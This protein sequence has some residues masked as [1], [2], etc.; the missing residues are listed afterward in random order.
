MKLFGSTT[1][2]YEAGLAFEC[3]GCGRCCAGPEEGYVW[4]TPAEIAAIAAH[5]GL[6]EAQMRRRYVRRVGR[7]FSLKERAESRD[8]V[9]L[10]PPASHD[11]RQVRGCRIYPVRPRQCRT[12]PFWPGNV[13]SPAAW[14]E[15]G[16]RC[17]GIN[18]GRVHGPDR[19]ER[20]RN[21]T[22]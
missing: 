19:I 1:A 5:L 18:R 2:W 15:A 7:R 21:G 8:C 10:L 14:A 12:W 20:N 17:P 22:P 13:S 4:V 11:G 9:F 16:T 6:S 3:Q